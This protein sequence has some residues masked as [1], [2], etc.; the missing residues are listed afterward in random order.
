M[1]IQVGFFK[2]AKSAP[3]GSEA[4]L[5]V[6]DDLAQRARIQYGNADFY[7]AAG[8]YAE[9]IDKLHTMYVIGQCRYR[10]PGPADSSIA[11]GLVS[12]TGAALAMDPQAPIQAL[13]Q[14]SIGYLEQ[15]VQIP[16]AQA[17]AGTYSSAMAELSRIL[18]SPPS[19]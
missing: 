19:R 13:V 18:A 16:Q 8:L 10:Q 3:A 9:A 1:E 7:S 15:I 5:Q 14:Q 2:R 6:P 12:A 4:H 17:E 11:E